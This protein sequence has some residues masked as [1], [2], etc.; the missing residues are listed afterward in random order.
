M[1]KNPV[2]KVERDVLATVRDY[3]RIGYDFQKGGMT[4]AVDHL[5]ALYPDQLATFRDGM[6]SDCV[7]SLV[8]TGYL[9]PVFSPNGQQEISSAHSLT[10]KGYRRLYE[11]EHPVSSWIAANWFPLSVASITLVVSIA[12]VVRSFIA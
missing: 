12:G 11:L 9:F 3:G 4:P 1:V 7:E 2:R 5:S 10:L 6:V 8:D